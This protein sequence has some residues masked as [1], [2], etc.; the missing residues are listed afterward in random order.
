MHPKS[1]EHD[2]VSLVPLRDLMGTEHP[3][4]RPDHGGAP[5]PG[6]S[7]VAEWRPWFLVH[8]KG[9]EMRFACPIVP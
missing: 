2:W 7:E 8:S 5:V 3:T 9:V 4:E 6:G 1:P